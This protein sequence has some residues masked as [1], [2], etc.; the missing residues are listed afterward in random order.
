[1]KGFAARR[2]FDDQADLSTPGGLMAV[3]WFLP[4][5]AVPVASP[6]GPTQLLHAW[7]AGDTSALD[8]LMPLLYDERSRP[9]HFGWFLA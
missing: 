4:N 5:A 3:T 7:R 9:A 1:M 8:R 2:R 6:A